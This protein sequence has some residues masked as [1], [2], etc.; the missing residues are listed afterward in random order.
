MCEGDQEARERAVMEKIAISKFKPHVLRYW[1]RTARPRTVD[2]H[3]L[4]TPVAQFRAGVGLKAVRKLV[5]N[6]G[7]GEILEILLGP[8]GDESDWEASTGRIG[9]VGRSKGGWQG[10]ST[11]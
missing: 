3:A 9:R 10:K 7:I 2:G 4:R 6:V 5:R 8:I 11:Q 1:R